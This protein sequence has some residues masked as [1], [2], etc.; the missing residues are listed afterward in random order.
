MVVGV[1]LFLFWNFYY[2]CSNFNNP[3]LVGIPSSDGKELYF[4]GII[5]IFTLYNLKKRSESTL[6][7]II[8]DKV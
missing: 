2:G 8:Y 1:T 6:K 4:I 7:S 3:V 5:D